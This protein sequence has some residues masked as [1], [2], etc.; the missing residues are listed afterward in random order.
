MKEKH[1]K[2]YG[3]SPE[4]PDVKPKGRYT[5]SEAAE[6]LNLHRNS[7]ANAFKAGTLRAIDPSATKVRYSG[8]ELYRFWHWKTTFG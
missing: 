2:P 6:K 7:I 5:T 1:R 3:I 4:P 8:K